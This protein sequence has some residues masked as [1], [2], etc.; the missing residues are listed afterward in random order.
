[1]WHSSQHRV[2]SSLTLP[3]TSV[4]ATP[5]R[6]NREEVGYDWELVWL[7]WARKGNGGTHMGATKSLGRVLLKDCF[8]S[9]MS[10]L[11]SISLNS[12]RNDLP[13]FYFKVALSNL[14]PIKSLLCSGPNKFFQ[15]ALRLQTLFSFLVLLGS[16]DLIFKKSRRHQLQWQERRSCLA[17]LILSEVSMELLHRIINHQ[18][19]KLLC[20]EHLPHSD[21]P[22]SGSTIAS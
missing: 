8:W 9:A 15:T 14:L 18:F 20:A 21:V 13:A 10:N 5:Q 12:H 16:P 4:A 17:N 6:I 7:L 22:T 11:W 3:C 1:M 19:L 2:G